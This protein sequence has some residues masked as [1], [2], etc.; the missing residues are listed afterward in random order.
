MIPDNTP[1]TPSHIGGFE[2]PVKTLSVEDK[3]I[4]WEMGGI[5]LND[6]SEGLR[7]QLWTFK[8]VVDE[9]TG[10][11]TVSVEAP[12][13]PK[14]TLFSGVDVGEIAGAFDQNMNPVVAYMESGAP[15]LWWWDP[16]ASAMVHTSL[17]AGC[18][19]LRVSLDDKRRFNV[20][21]SDVILSYVRGGSLYYRYQ[22]D[23][24][25]VEYLLSE[26]VD[27]LVCASMN[28]LWCF[29]WRA[30][31]T[32]DGV[33]DSFSE[34]FLGDIVYDLCRQA[35]LRPEQID[36]SEL[37][38]PVTDRVPGLLVNIDEGLDKPIKWLMEMFNF[39]KV[40]HGKRLRFIKRGR[41]VVAR[42]PYNKLIDDFPTTLKREE[43]DRAKLPRTVNVNHIDPDGGFAKNKQTATR[44]TNMTIGNAILNIDS[45]VV[46]SRDQAALAAMRKLKL[47]HN[48]TVDYAFSTGLEYTYLTPGDVVEVEDADGTWYRMHITERNEDDGTIAWEAE[49][50]GGSLVYDNV[51]PPG[52]ELDPPTPTT[53]GLIGDT[54]LEILNIPVQNGNQD[55]LGLYIAARGSA[56]GWTGYSLSYSIDAGVT[57]VP[58]Y[59]SQLS[60]N[61]GETVTT[62]TATSTS[63]EVLMP[64]PME[65]GTAAQLAVGYKRAVIGDEEVQYLTAT[66]LGMVDGK[67]H[68]S[69]TGLVRGVLDTLAEPWGAG[70][71][72]VDADSGVLFLQLQREFFGMDIYYKATSFGQPDDEVTAV[73]YLFDHAENQT[74][75]QVDDLLMVANPTGPGVKVTWTERPR[76]GTFGVAPYHSKHF[77]GYRLKFTGGFTVDLPPGATSYTYEA[78]N[79][80][81]ET[82]EFTSVNAITGPNAAQ[83]I[84]VTPP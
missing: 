9:L 56:D 2:V 17:P 28:S 49:A 44:R 83:N 15:K 50:D 34:P 52:K 46:L 27:R 6:P 22:R 67:Y 75:W 14:V 7:V 82:L 65:S 80:V 23:R 57:Y 20:A 59:T 54:I 71:R 32:G 45:R 31:G 41:D 69:L 55:E 29:Q 58:A 79:S 10:D 40:E 47:E 63:V 84:G 1:A 19:D 48:E 21:E 33:G 13:V 66:L 4:D 64:Y 76:L 62:V 36:V 77:L 43:R 26:N 30:L 25:L 3:F 24:Y 5:A 78:G 37:Y 70:I 51:A 68:Y 53:P 38:D 73:A 18:Y 72:F 12:S 81:S 35:G 8:L 61:I 60:A 42:I 74:E 16:T 39:T 11:S